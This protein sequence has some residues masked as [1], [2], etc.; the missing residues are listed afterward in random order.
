LGALVFDVLYVVHRLLQ[1]L[2][3]DDATPAGISAFNL[4]H[5]SALLASEVAV[6]LA[7]LALIVFIAAFASLIRQAGRDTLATA[8]TVSG[9]VF[10][11][12]GFISQ[13][14]ETALVGV[15]DAGDQS[16]VLALNQLQGWIPIVWTIT[17]LTVAVSLA[18]LRTR[19]LPTWLGVAGLLTAGVFV[20][21]SMSSVLG[22]SRGQLVAIRRGPVPRVAPA[23]GR[24][25]VAGG[26][27]RNARVRSRAPTVGVRRAGRPDEWAR[28]PSAGDMKHGVDLV[29]V[30]AGNQQTR[31]LCGEGGEVNAPTTSLLENLRHDRQRTIGASA[32]DQP[33]SAP[34]EL[35]L[36]RQRSMPELIAVWL[37]RLLLT[38]PHPA[39][40]DDDVVLVL[41][42]LDLDG[43]EPE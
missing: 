38:L 1:G 6:G 10:V 13:A 12:M 27:Y 43:S 26:G 41:P 3:P 14:A 33:A 5:R 15:A 25:P 20:L 21:G 17:A 16:A 28:C 23:R 40:L 24:L 18:G 37:R 8:V 39:T 7:L 30:E 2:G 35:L 34:G 4:A 11:A 32:D 29:P 19:L 36:S 42:P 31:V 9:A 22:R